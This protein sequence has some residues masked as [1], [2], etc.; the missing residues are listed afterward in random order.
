MIRGQKALTVVQSIVCLRFGRI[1][2]HSRR[3]CIQGLRRPIRNLKPNVCQDICH[4]R[5][6]ML[7]KEKVFK[8]SFFGRPAEE[9]ATILPAFGIFP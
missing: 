4:A 1:L 7:K 9:S 3:V 8:I 2:Q 6:V 5:R